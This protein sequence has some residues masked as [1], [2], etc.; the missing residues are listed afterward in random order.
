[1]GLIALFL[2]PGFENTKAFGNKCQIPANK[3]SKRD[4]GKKSCI[5]I[6]LR[7]MHKTVIFYF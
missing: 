7:I 6:K 2:V 1:M 5:A 3:K 4:I